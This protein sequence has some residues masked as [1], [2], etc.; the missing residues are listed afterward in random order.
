MDTSTVPYVTNTPDYGPY[1]Y[2]PFNRGNKLKR[3]DKEGGF[4]NSDR[5]SLWG[6]TR[7]QE[8]FHFTHVGSRKILARKTGPKRSYDLDD[9]EPYASIKV[10]EIWTP[11]DKVEDVRKNKSLMHSLRSRHIKMLAETAIELIEREQGFNKLLN[12]LADVVH[13]DD[14][15]THDKMNIEEGLNPKGLESLKAV[16]ELVEEN[17]GCGNEYIQQLGNIRNKLTRVYEQKKSLAKNVA[18]AKAKPRPSGNS[19]NGRR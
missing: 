2:A 5:P 6:A 10:D 17:I 16:R 14:P 18:P 13:S 11:P 8:D 7:V 9:D 3:R 1:N 12:R 19:H 4:P 15:A